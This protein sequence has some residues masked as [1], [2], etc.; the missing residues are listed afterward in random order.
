MS[1]LT[2]QYRTTE[3]HESL[4]IGTLAYFKDAIIKT[5]IYAGNRA[6][7][8]MFKHHLEGE[9][10]VVDVAFQP[11]GRVWQYRISFPDGCEF[12]A[13]PWE[14]TPTGDC[15]VPLAGGHVAYHQDQLVEH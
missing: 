3:G 15:G 11:D 5:P 4:T 8:H 7:R 10:R 13:N 12:W 6:E 9:A 2:T 1:I 14:V